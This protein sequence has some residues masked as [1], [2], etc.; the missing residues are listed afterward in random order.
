[1]PQQER[2]VIKLPLSGVGFPTLM[3]YLRQA[4]QNNQDL[5]NA[6]NLS[7]Q[8]IEAAL[9]DYPSAASVSIGTSGWV[10]DN[11]AT[12]SYKYYYDITEETST[13]NDMPVLAIA[14]E[15]LATAA[16]CGLCS[17]CQSMSGKVR[18]YAMSVPTSPMSGSLMI[19]PGKTDVNLTTEETEET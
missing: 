10:K 18:I 16:V 13:V 7:L 14:P 8:E 17:S 4:L 19:M 6:L 1:M 12:H 9:N 5:S 2:A 3:S 11:N 15:S